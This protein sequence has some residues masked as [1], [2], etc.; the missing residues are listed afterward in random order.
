MIKVRKIA[1]WLF[2]IV[3][4]FFV[5]EMVKK[6]LS[7]E[8]KQ[9][10]EVENSKSQV[11]VIVGDSVFSSVGKH[12]YKISA[13]NVVQENNGMYYLKHV[14]G[15]YTID[16]NQILDLIAASGSIDSS[17]DAAKFTDGV[18]LKYVGY[19]LV[20]SKLDINFKNH[21]AVAPGF[22]TIKGK[23]ANV[24]ANEFDA[25]EEFNL[26]TF[27]GDVKADFILHNSR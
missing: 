1:I 11:S 19:E 13:Q 4:L 6:Q 15:F 24:T 2:L 12:P 17:V 22:V 18:N 27:H 7:L 23:N 3:G 10:L 21:S 8:K 16:N 26:I 9:N 25:S 5:F 14:S 20:T